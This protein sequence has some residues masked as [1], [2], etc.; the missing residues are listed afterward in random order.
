[1][2]EQ[3][4][5][6]F[7]D[8]RSTIS[9]CARIVRRRWR[10]ALSGL[11]AIATVAFWYSQYVP[12]EYSAA[13]VFER[14]DDV[15]LQNLVKRNSPYGFDHLKTT[16]TLDMTG[17]RAQALALV[18]MGLLSPEE[19]RPDGAL[20]HDEQA[21]VDRMRARY[22]LRPSVRFINS[23]P[24]LDTI[25]LTCTANDPQVAAD[26]VIA[27]RDSYVAQTRTRIRDILTGTRSFFQSEVERL[28]A[29]R[30]AVEDS[31]RGEFGDVPGLDPTDSTAVGA[32]LEALRT[33]QAALYQRHA[34][35]QA[36]IAAREQ[37]LQK[38]PGFINPPANA[39]DLPTPPAALAPGQV[40]LDPALEAAI[41]ETR[42]ELL[43]ARTTLEMTDEHPEVVR[44]T[45]KLEALT[46]LRTQLIAR[47]A[48]QPLPI[49]AA[50]AVAS[51]SV[52]P[53]YRDWQMQQMRV[54]LELTA[55]REQERV[56]G[57]Q[58][59]DAAGRF[60]RVNAL[61]GRLAQHADELRRI[62]SQQIDGEDELVVWQS[63]LAQLERVL[64]AESGDRGTQFTLIE[65]PRG[66]A[67]PSQP[68]VASVFAVCSGLGIAAAALFVAL[69]ELFDRSYRSANQVARSLGVPVLVSIGVIPTPRER[70]RRVMSRVVWAPTLA[71]LLAALF[72]SGTLAYTSL[73]LPALHDRAL[74][75]LE[76]PLQAIGAAGMLP[77]A[78]T[79]P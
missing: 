38:V 47:A 76:R 36:E 53:L 28:E 15:V 69:A 72:L 62:R 60:E 1:M 12:R 29:E 79:T 78:A 31:L 45:Q 77:H 35:L 32:R 65:E 26:F 27:L 25:Q 59:A 3:H 9:E 23:T 43:E 57:T 75:Q 7:E 6:A 18:R 61:Y 30:I 50:P 13:T 67:T 68:R 63:H 39:A 52:D 49:A 42:Q 20:S 8:L 73:A 21:A 11:C 66:A 64:A 71:V 34:E 33:Q 5:Q 40:E 70:R 10:L 14:R 48:E 22:T 74:A 24:A 16:M 41:R 37:F 58:L 44:L 17:S 2:S 4:G 19:I 46:E 54:Q 56:A 51:H 55:L